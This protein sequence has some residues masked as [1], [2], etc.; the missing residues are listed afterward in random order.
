M[1]TLTERIMSKVTVDKKTQC[2]NW[3]GSL[4]KK[5]S[6]S[7]GQ[8][9]MCGRKGKTQRAHRVSYENFVGKIPDGL[10]IDHL[11]QNTLCVNPNH[12]Q[13]VTHSEN[14]RRGRNAKKTH[15]VN[16]HKRT[17]ENIYI[18]TRGAKECRI[19]LKENQR[20]YKMKNA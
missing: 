2:W 18:N 1:E 5:P 9:R 11:C 7:Y 10:S 15:C 13:P 16:G 12:L 14:M 4:F 20:R 3:T 19:C 17:S 8:L 6:G